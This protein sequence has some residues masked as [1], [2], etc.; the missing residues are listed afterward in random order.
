MSPTPTKLQAESKAATSLRPQ[1][2]AEARLVRAA[3]RLIY[4]AMALTPQPVPKHHPVAAQGILLARLSND[5]SAGLR[6]AQVG[7]LLQMW[8]MTSTLF[9]HAFC[10]GAIGDSQERADKWFSHK[11]WERTPWSVADTIRYTLAYID[12]PAK[13]YDDLY[14]RYKQMCAAKHANPV[15][16]QH[17]GVVGDDSVTRIQL[18]PRYLKDHVPLYQLG[19][20]YAL[21]AVGIAVWAFAKDRILDTHFTR[22][23]KRFADETV[24]RHSTLRETAS[25]A[26]NNQEYR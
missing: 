7:Y 8:T 1:L 6:L 26:V 5:L 23:L 4:R 3:D 21:Q 24:S 16:Q 14:H 15:I 12:L 10:V 22:Q 11:K 18:D 19:L 2:Q 13:R 20:N 25:H 9:E 17:F